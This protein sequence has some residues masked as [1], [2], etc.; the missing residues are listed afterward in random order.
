M[1]INNMAYWNKS[2]PEIDLAQ[3]KTGQRLQV[4]ILSSDDSE[5]LISLN[6][7][8]MK[9]KLEAQV[10]SG[11]RFW[12]AVK[13]IDENGMVVLSREVW[14]SQTLSR[15]S[16]EQMLTLLDRG[17]GFDPETAEVLLNFARNQMRP[18]L[19]PLLASANPQ[20]NNLLTELLKIVP[21]WSALNG[22]NYGRLWQYNLR[23]G[24][25]NERTLYQNFLA[26][27][28]PPPENTPSVK[29]IL[30][31]TLQD[32]GKALSKEEKSA[33]EKILAEITGQQLW[34]QSGTKKNAYSLLHFILQDQGVFYNCRVA[35]ESSRK[36]K[37]KDIQHS[38]I[39]L[40]VETPN[41]GKVGVDFLIYDN[42]INICLLHDDVAELKAFLEELQPETAANFHNLGLRLER[43]TVKSFTELPDFQDFLSGKPR[44]GVDIKG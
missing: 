16:Q 4:E 9:A 24:L 40:Q 14:N 25:E 33:L 34:V 19:D 22:K 37:K 29:E 44:S 17:T 13:E 8:L 39:A 27:N 28:E 6:G 32:P 43:V 20:I 18:L 12:A 5:G 3:L 2:G 41:L 23:L 15:L 35:L 7:T 11:D 30:L 42:A 10:Q 26:K 36:G 38:H 21:E 31:K 1:Q